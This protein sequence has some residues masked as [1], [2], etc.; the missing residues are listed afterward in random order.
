MADDFWDRLTKYYAMV[1]G[2]KYGPIDY[3]LE[4]QNRPTDKGTV[5]NVAREFVANMATAVPD[6]FLGL[7][8]MIDTW[9]QRDPSLNVTDRYKMGSVDPSA[10]PPNGNPDYVSPL[11]EKHRDITDPV[12]RALDLPTEG[13]T[14][15]GVA[16]NALAAMTPIGWTRAAMSGP[17]QAGLAF[18]VPYNIV[19]S[20]HALQDV[21]TAGLVASGVGSGIKLA[22]GD[23]AGATPVQA[24][25][26]EPAAPAVVNTLTFESANRTQPNDNPLTFPSNPLAFPQQEPTASPK[27]DSIWDEVKLY[28][29]GAALTLG[30]L[31]GWH[32]YTMNRATQQAAGALP[33]TQ[34][35]EMETKL[36]LGTTARIAGVD[37]NR[38][39]G[40]VVEQG[41]TPTGRSI[42]LTDDLMR[43]SAKNIEDMAATR[44]RDAGGG[45][46]DAMYV[47]GKMPN[48]VV[49]MPAPP[50][51]WFSRESALDPERR[52]AFRDAMYGR[53]E[54]EDRALFN[55]DRQARGLPPIPDNVPWQAAGGKPGLFP[56][57]STSELAQMYARLTGDPELE[58]LR[59]AHKAYQSKIVDYLLDRGMITPEAAQFLKT[60]RP[61]H[62]HRQI[63]EE[64][65]SFWQRVKN[66]IFNPN[67]DEP[68]IQT[69]L[70]SLLAREGDQTKSALGVAEA[71]DRQFHSVVHGTEQNAI[72]RMFADIITNRVTV[73]GAG[74]FATHNAHKLMREVASTPN[75]AKNVLAV[76]GD[77]EVLI[78]Y[79]DRTKKFITTPEIATALRFA[80]GTAVPIANF[81]RK[82]AQ[83]AITGKLNPAFAPTSFLYDVWMSSIVEPVIKGG[84]LNFVPVLDPLKGI[85]QGVYGRMVDELSHQLTRQVDN[86]GVIA[87]AVGRQ[88]LDTIAKQVQNAAVGSTLLAARE[89][90]ALGR[91]KDSVGV[92]TTVLRR[93]APD[94]KYST[95][96]P[97]VRHAANTADL[98]VRGYNGLLDAIQEGTK[99]GAFSRN[100]NPAAARDISGDFSKVPM[101]KRVQQVE[102]TIPYARVGVVSIDKVMRAL[103]ERPV[104][105]TGRALA[106]ITL[107]TIAGAYAMT[108][109]SPEHRDFFWNKLTPEQRNAGIWLPLDPAD[110]T[111]SVMIP[112]DPTLGAMFITPGLIAADRMMGLSTGEIDKSPQLKA[113]LGMLLGLPSDVSFAGYQPS[114]Q[115]NTYDAYAALTAAG[116][117]APLDVPV[118]VAA[119]AAALGHR[120]DVRSLLTGDNVVSNAARDNTGLGT[121][122]EGGLFSETAYNILDA[123]VGLTGRSVLNALEVTNDKRHLGQK[124]G[125][126]SVTKDFTE[127]MIG[128]SPS[129]RIMW[130]AP[131]R[132]LSQTPEAKALAKNER[133]MGDVM[134]AYNTFIRNEPGTRVG[135]SAVTNA[136]VPP[137]LQ[138]PEFYAIGSTVQTMKPRLDTIK[139][140]INDLFAVR[141]RLEISGQLPQGSRSRVDALNDQLQVIQ[142]KRREAAEI[143]SQMEDAISRQIG[144]PFQFQQLDLK[145]PDLG[146]SR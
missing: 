140:E 68:R 108:M 72:A 135:P 16:G 127:R 97:G 93:I 104:E 120:I 37:Q 109:M 78:R 30:A 7:P 1:T 89:A 121:R 98:I 81:M 20:G 86:N 50:R 53:D 61:N 130:D 52:G 95:L 43:S 21:A 146:L 45:L 113:T 65:S 136:P 60:A 38:I 26:A 103:K 6:V 76:A 132:M 71:L 75:N 44:M 42:G 74:S 2:G 124:V 134:N 33:L 128:S 8:G 31:Y 112:V 69:A 106:A 79:A 10:A 40:A 57:K 77:N 49:Q 9:R 54:I 80:P 47:S 142:S 66:G 143:V 116:R 24:P 101:N 88:N 125:M 129:L 90:G 56:D 94:V 102:S 96:P 83:S 22:V 55:A 13:L 3:G 19:R 35:P 48:S 119:A 92:G 64:A 122:Y 63:Q 11:I 114:P 137:Q 67:V 133:V 28:G 15:E 84:R 99:L 62:V 115:Q 85:V 107:P 23:D 58:W 14:W 17:Q 105:T 29:A 32:R 139:S 39:L 36:G 73:P 123:T 100:R 110:P 59:D 82:A 141:Q 118:P 145:R 4:N 34:A 25:S 126:D 27:Q 111:R 138:S 117:F 70:Q 5:S 18:A 46:M 87:Q 144:R 91:H 12:R 131:V 51:Q 41:P